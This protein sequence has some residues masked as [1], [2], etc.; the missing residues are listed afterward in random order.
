[1]QPALKIHRGC[2]SYVSF[3]TISVIS[4]LLYAFRVVHE[5]DR[6]I[7]QTS[8]TLGG[9]GGGGGSSSSS[10]SI[11]PCTQHIHIIYSPYSPNRNEILNK[12]A[13]ILKN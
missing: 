1:M 2:Y 9:G 12:S 7:D 13:R 5:F 10:S 4:G 8:T 3:R 6:L 11:S